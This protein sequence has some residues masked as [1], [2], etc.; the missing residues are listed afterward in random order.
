MIFI[1]KI[2]LQ[3]KGPPARLEGLALMNVA[4]F[5]GASDAFKLA[6][7]SKNY[8]KNMVRSS[9]MEDFWCAS[10]LQRL[11]SKTGYL[12]FKNKSLLKIDY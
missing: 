5:V 8:Y 11:N 9:I 3:H 1:N 4:H 12:G 7:L 6:S 10:S 2:N